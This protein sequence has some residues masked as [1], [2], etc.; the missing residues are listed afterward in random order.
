MH[1]RLPGI[2]PHAVVPTRAPVI[3][4]AIGMALIA[5]FRP[6]LIAPTAFASL[7]RWPIRPALT[8]FLIAW[9]SRCASRRLGLVR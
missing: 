5:T 7:E 2:T 4:R 1:G 6:T 3:T 9:R 8:L